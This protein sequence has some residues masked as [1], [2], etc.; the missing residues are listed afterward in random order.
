[1]V[2]SDAL[3][4]KD[5]ECET[6]VR[7]KMTNETNKTPRKKTS[8]PLDLVHMDL[9]G[10]V[11]PTG[12]DGFRYA[13]VCVDDFTGL[14]C[15]Y[16]LKNKAD[17]ILGLKTYLSDMAPYGRVKSIRSDQGGEFESKEFHKLCLDNKIVHERS[18]PQ[19]PHQNGTAERQWRTLFEVSGCLLIDSKLPKSLW[20][21]AL[22]CSSFIRNSCFN[23]RLTI[24]PFEAMTDKKSN[25]EKMHT[26]GKACFALVQNPKKLSDRAE[27]G[28][29]VGYDKRSP[30][31]LVYFPQIEK[32]KKVRKVKFLNKVENEMLNENENFDEEQDS[33]HPICEPNAAP[34]Q[35]VS[36]TGNVDYEPVT[37]DNISDKNNDEMHGE[38]SN[39][40]ARNT[41]TRKKTKPKYLDDY[42]SGSEFD[43]CETMHN[44]I[45]YCYNVSSTKVPTSYT[46]AVSSAESQQWHNT[47]TEEM[48]ALEE[49]ETYEL[50]TLPEN[51]KAIGGRWVYTLKTDK[52]NKSTYKA[53]YVAKGYSQTKGVDYNET[54]SPTA[55]MTSI[56][57]LM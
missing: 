35:N 19:S 30:A 7:G 28:I 8:E 18:A 14:S 12:Y 27:K 44:V 33:V 2:I 51:R 40:N 23:T 34:D 52:E 39:S 29:F 42:E 48:K 38:I 46:A 31:Y 5:F 57:V 13:L 56:R 10:P 32:V 41:K 45:H 3:A 17:A 16:L 24:T 54:F 4:H 37:Q 47:M 50:V 43:E 55:N 49:N 20:P 1:M 26:F 6:C 53:R 36:D 9:A 21:Y 15:V 11:D 25:L 22:M